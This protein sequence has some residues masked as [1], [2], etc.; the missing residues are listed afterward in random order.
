[1]NLLQDSDSFSF[2]EA[3]EYLA[4]VFTEGLLTSATIPVSAVMDD[5]LLVKIDNDDILPDRL[6]FLGIASFQ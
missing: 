4:Y 3:Q 5:R 1:M 2:G 6:P